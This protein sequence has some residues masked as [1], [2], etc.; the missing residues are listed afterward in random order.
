MSAL[1]GN[2]GDD[3]RE[4]RLFEHASLGDDTALAGLIESYLPRLR[5]YVRAQIGDDLRRWCRN[6][7]R[8][9]DAGR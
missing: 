4:T 3:N 1:N 9:T 8:P 7:L 2:E 5:G 6:P